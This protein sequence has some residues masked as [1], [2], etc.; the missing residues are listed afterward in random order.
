MGLVFGFFLVLLLFYL[1]ECAFFPTSDQHYFATSWGRRFRPDSGFELK[2]LN[3][4]RLVL[5]GV[6]PALGQTFLARRRNADLSDGS[7]HRHR[8]SWVQPP[9]SRS[10]ALI[11]ESLNHREAARRLKLYREATRWLKPSCG[12]LAIFLLLALPWIDRYGA[13]RIW[14][15]LLIGLVTLQSGVGILFWR[16]HRTLFPDLPGDRLSVVVG[17]VLWPP[18]AIRAP[19]RLSL[20]LLEPFDP[21]VVAHQLCGGEVFKRFAAWK[22]HDLRRETLLVQSQPGIPTKAVS[23]PLARRAALKGFL[24]SI[25]LSGDALESAP[26]PDSPQARSYCPLCR[27]QFALPPERCPD[28]GLPLRDFQSSSSRSQAKVDQD[29]SK[30]VDEPVGQD[31]GPEVSAREHEGRP[32]DQP[33]HS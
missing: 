20:A 30:G 33:G 23:W 11:G 24:A 17:I 12:L 7:R 15:W 16:A 3:R 9:V 2:L 5:A 31:A 21:V 22:L 1:W 8:G 13:D 10:R 4:Y 28:C 6:V 27:D 32:E 14:P 25:G 19:D 29:Q 26:T 18:A